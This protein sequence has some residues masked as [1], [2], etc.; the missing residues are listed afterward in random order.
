MFTPPWTLLL[1]YLLQHQVDGFI[2]KQ[3]NEKD[4]L[5]KPNSNFIHFSIIIAKNLNK[6]AQYVLGISHIKMLHIISLYYILS[7][8]ILYHYIAYY[9]V[10]HHTII[11]QLLCYISYYYVT[12]HIIILCTTLSYYILLL[13]IILLYYISC[14]IL[15]CYMYHYAYFWHTHA[16]L[17]DQNNGYTHPPVLVLMLTNKHKEKKLSKVNGSK[18]C[19]IRNNSIVKC[20][21]ENIVNSMYCIVN[22]HLYVVVIVLCVQQTDIEVTAIHTLSG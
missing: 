14:Y 5:I 10:T 13:Y 15:S 4:Y 7:C 11:L 2:E 18:L 21:L 8:C 17:T 22:G 19:T 9:Y 1:E 20:K 12:H 6:Q 3:T 16:T